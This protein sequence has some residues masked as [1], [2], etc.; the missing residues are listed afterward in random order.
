MRIEF[1]IESELGQAKRRRSL[2][3]ETED[4]VPG[5]EAEPWIAA[6]RT[7]VEVVDVL[8]SDFGGDR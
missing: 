1:V 8:E 4:M 7:A 2:V 3:V 5:M 6:W